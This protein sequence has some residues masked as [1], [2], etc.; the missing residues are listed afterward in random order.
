LQKPADPKHPENGTLR[1]S[2]QVLEAAGSYEPEL[3]AV[4]V[5]E[6]FDYLWRLF[7]EIFQ[8]ASEGFSGPRL[9]WRDLAEYQAVTGIALDAFEVEVIMAMGQAVRSEA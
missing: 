7:W 2:L 9:T 3:H 6:G 8:G 5:P 4:H 1:E